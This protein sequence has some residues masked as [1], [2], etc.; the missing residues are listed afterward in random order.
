LAERLGDLDAVGPI[1]QGMNQP[2]ND[3]SR[4]CSTDD[5]YKMIAITANQAIGAKPQ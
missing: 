3:L 2:V 5:I 4:G 1:L